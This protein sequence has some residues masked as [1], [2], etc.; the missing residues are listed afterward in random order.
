MIYR[1]LGSSGLKVSEIA[2]GN[3]ITHGAQVNNE[4]AYAC[5]HAALDAGITTF[6]T[7]DA[8]SETRAETVLGQALKGMR[9]E[10]IELCTKV[11]H[12]T[13]TGHNDRGLSRKHIMEACH[14]SLNRLQTDYI[15]VYYAHRFDSTVSLEETFLAFS[16]LV[17]QGKILYVGISEWTADQIAKGAALAREL[18]VPLVASQPQYSM[19]WRVIESEVIHVCEREGI[20]QVVWSPLAQGILS[21]K[22]APNKPLP[23]G[24]RASTSAGA[25]FF[26][27]LAGQW[28]RTEVLLAVS[29]LSS[30]AHE[31]G[32]TLPQ[33]AIAWVLQNPQVSSAIIGASK[34]EQ[35]QE[36]VKAAG[37]RL[38]SEMMKQIDTILDGLVER[39]PAKTG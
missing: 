21:G 37:T 6:D 13:G 35:V 14:A 3:W 29:K 27:R 4:T 36:N 18:R 31:A 30:I 15:D 25:P 1:K 17:R 2:L 5:V 16:D 24:S 22:Y 7:A 19:L 11:Y 34:P 33:L 12:P 39:D 26:E 23:Q 10:S 8:Y 28:L 20:G 38:D 32:L 9:R